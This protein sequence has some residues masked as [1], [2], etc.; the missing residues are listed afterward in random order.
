MSQS[1]TK[2]HVRQCLGRFCLDVPD[3]MTRSPDVETYQVQHIFLE[4]ALWKDSSDEARSKVWKTR[5]DGIRALAGERELPEEPQGTILTQ[6]A[7][8]PEVQGVLYHRMD[9]PLVATWGALLHS[10]AA[11][12][13]MQI[14][15]DLEREQ[16][17][18]TRVKEV[19]G[20]YRLPAPGEPLPHPGK[21]W[22]YLRHGMVALPT[23]YQE[24]ARV[25]FEGTALKVKVDVWTRTA[26]KVKK[27]S[28][29]ERLSGTLARAGGDFAGDIVT[30]R[31]QS[32]TVAGLPG[33]EMIIRYK[34]GKRMGLYFL[35]S[36]SGEEKS[37]ARPRFNIEMDTGLDQDDA[38]VELW[39]SLLGSVRPVTQ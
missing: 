36:Y 3:S 17:W 23:K 11:D 8:S 18:A 1:P 34:E 25:R 19:S 32:R 16:D 12:V 24:E 9:N 2:G 33:E 5:L 13:W 38:K 14:D 39:N 6:R 29:L 21:D 35:W 10:G 4:E 22:F 28:L 27:E 31:Y 7:L 15:G 26:T 30:Q 20:A 37:G